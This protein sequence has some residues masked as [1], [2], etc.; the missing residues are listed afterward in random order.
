MVRTSTSA[1][2]IKVTLRHIRPP[3]WRRIVV[4]AD[5]T[6][7]NLHS[8]LQTAFG[9]ED[10]HLHMFTAGGMNYGIPSPDDWAPV[11]DERKVT[12]KQVLREPKD[13]LMYEYDFGDSWEHSVVLEKVLSSP[14]GPT[15]YC[16]GGRRACPPED[17]GGPSGYAM[18]LDAITD[19]EHPEHLDYLQWVGG[20]FDAEACNPEEI[21]A[22][23]GVYRRRGSSRRAR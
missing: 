12:L 8:I 3:V 21:S 15:P 13:G 20:S 7:A 2:Q 10:Y 6:L 19:A 23:L 11:R 18:F 16:S 9:W 22:E 4:D 1:L 17:C 14:E 5:A